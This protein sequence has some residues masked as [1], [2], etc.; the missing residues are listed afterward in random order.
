MR[1]LL[2][3]LLAAA[4]CLHL[5]DSLRCYT[6]FAATSHKGCLSETTCSP[7][8]KYCMTFSN[9][10]SGLTL[11]NKRCAPTCKSTKSS[12]SSSVSMSCCKDDLCN[13]DS[14]E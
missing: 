14:D 8:D 3:S 4:V 6:C 11:I 7:N 2:V 5:A 13:D 1:I 10:T 12:F 9:S